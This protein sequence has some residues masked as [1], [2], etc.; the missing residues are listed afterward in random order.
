MLFGI[1]DGTVVATRK[2]D[3]IR[4]TKYLLVRICNHRGEPAEGYVV[5]LDLVGA[6]D[7]ELIVLSQGSSARQTD[8]TYQK[9]IDAVI[10]GIVDLVEENGKIVYKK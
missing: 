9:P 4:G 7:G 8:C 1:V 3:G 5:A 10:A 6:G 2:E